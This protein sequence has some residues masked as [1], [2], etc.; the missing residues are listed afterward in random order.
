MVKELELVRSTVLRLEE[1]L[2]K[3]KKEHDVELN[4]QRSSFQEKINRLQTQL[5]QEIKNKNQMT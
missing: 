4:K 2:E 5:A 3:Q 1:E